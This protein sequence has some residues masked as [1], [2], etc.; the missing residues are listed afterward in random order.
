[1]FCSRPRFAV[2]L[3]EG[4]RGRW[5]FFRVVYCPMFIHDWKYQTSSIDE[6]RTQVDIKSKTANIELRQKLHTSFNVMLDLT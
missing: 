5:I 2:S 3:G 6:R 4:S 1:M